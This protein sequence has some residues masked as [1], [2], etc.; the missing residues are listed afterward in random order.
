M[1]LRPHR[2][3]THSM[4][5]QNRPV[6]A[7]SAVTGQGTTELLR[8]VR[9]VL[10]STLEEPVVEEPKVFRPTESEDAF[11]ITR[12]GGAFHVRGK[13]IER[14]AAMTDWANDEAVARFQRIIKAMGIQEALEKAGVELEDTVIIGD[15]ELEW[16]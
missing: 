11:E 15:H 12:E 7:I 14:V 4:R 2:R 9:Q 1:K 13:R 6:F 10:E 8:M 5:A 3:S 16:Q